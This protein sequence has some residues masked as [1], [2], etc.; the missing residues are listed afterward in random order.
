MIRKS[1][2]LLSAGMVAVA[3]PA[4]AQQPPTQPTVPDT[5]QT[6]AAPTTSPTSDSAAV[7]NTAQEQ[8]PVD[9][10]NIIITATRRNQAL[11]DVP[12][13]VSAV[14]ADTLQNSGAT[15]I[16]Q[17]NQL[18]PSLLVS[19]TQS[20]AGASVARIRGIGTVGDNPGLEG[21]V[22]TY[23]DGVYRS[24][25]GGA[26]TE[27]GPLDRV[28]VLRGPQGTLFGRNA[29]AG[30]ISVI[31]AKPQFTPFV[32]GALSVGNYRYVRLD[33]TI[34][35][36]L[37][38]TVAGRIDG[39]LLSRNG[40]IKDVISGRRVNDRRRWLLRGQLLFQPT[41]DLSIRL[42]ADYAK[43]NEECCAAVYLPASDYVAG[44]GEAPSSAKALLTALGATI[45]DDPY[46]RQTAITPGR[47]YR[48]DVKDGGLSAEVKYDLGAAEVTSITAYRT[49]DYIGGGDFDYNNLD[50]L[51]RDDDGNYQNKFKTFTQEL[52]LQGEL[53]DGRLDWLV[54]GFYANE[55]ITRRDNLS[56]GAAIDPFARELIRAQ[57]PVLAAFP[58]FNNL[59]LFAQGF[60]LNQLTTNPAL[61]A[62]PV[63]A[64]PLIINAIA[65][66]VV[67]T[68]LANTVT[69]DDF[70]QKGTNYALF[71]HN[72]FKVTDQLSLTLGARYTV[73]RK[74]ITAD[75]ASNS[76]CAN[77]RANITRLQ[78]LAAAAAANP[79]GNFGLNPAIAA[80][81]TA[82]SG[83]VLNPIGTLPCAIN[84]IN[85]SFESDTKTEKKF[86]GTAVLSFKPTPEL[87]TYASYSRGY[88]AGGF[89][90]DRA[91]LNQAAVDLDDLRFKPELV[92]AYEVGA[93]YNGRGFDVNVAL[94]NEDFRNFQ[95]NTFNGINFVVEN[96]N[97]C[98]EGLNGA[99]TDNS[100]VAVPCGGKRKAGVRSRGV[101]IETFFRPIRDVNGAFGL[102]YV[103]AK[104]RNDLVGTAD[105]A[106]L[107]PFFQLPGRQISNAPKLTLTGSLGYTPPI[108]NSGM[109]ALFYVDARRTSSYNTGSD[110]DI[111]KTQDPFTVVN[112]RVGIRGPLETWALELWAQNLFNTKYTQVGFDAFGQGTGTRRGVDAGFYARSTQL[113][114]AFLG[115]PRTFGLTLR[116][117]LGT[118]RAAPVA[119]VAPPAPPPPPVVVEQPVAP[120]PPPAPVERGERG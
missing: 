64:R 55:K 9:S 102:T 58:G 17:L 33:E 86:S 42:I 59:N 60:V 14:T 68:P 81:A 52:R 91:G 73:D 32:A 119:Y 4:F 50:L 95:L 117:K 25:T 67:N 21:S 78:Q 44:T 80:L 114:A 40:F 84:S 38:D 88:K 23:I 6:N 8:Q 111:E 85:G 11:S 89:N 94:F 107:P 57:S 66:Q 2:W 36:P 92:D 26:L 87:L 18:S 72:I 56:T 82:L 71:T 5:T 62:V 49:N 16:R 35:M 7:A 65:S 70:R 100:S 3:T 43:R 28:E 101:E 46:R 106:L 98:S 79:G 99:D 37:S 22:A 110:L 76:Q 39:V 41:T 24:R 47:F 116:G 61:A 120:P 29:S 115:E 96:I 97:S 45:I 118:G 103:N 27:L 15:D 20:E 113:Y 108:G 109:H 31:T 54:G 53:M 19:S 10:G 13:A 105:E 34:N 104:Y 1:A 93:K 48:S 51:Y 74:S 112:A 63:F 77:Y 12:L 30:V 83:Q 90:L 75:L 69:Q